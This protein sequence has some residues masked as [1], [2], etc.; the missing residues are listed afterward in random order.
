MSDELFADFPPEPPPALRA[1]HCDAPLA[2]RLRPETFEDFLGQEDLLGPG[3][4]LRS[5]IE[6]GTIPSIIFWGPPGCGKTTL[7]LLIAKTLHADVALLSAVTSQLRE[8]RQVLEQARR[9]RQQARRTLLFV[10]EIHR[11][12]KAQQDAFLPAVESGIITLI[13]ATTENPSFSVIAPL[14]SRCRVFTLKRL[15]ESHLLAL[16]GRALGDPARGL[17]GAQVRVGEDTL[18]S[19]IALSDGDARKALSLLE[20]GVDAARAQEA[21]ELTG[22]TLQA[23][24][25]RHLIYDRSGEEHF[26]LISAFHKSLRSSDPQ[27][28][29]YWLARMLASG[30]DPLYVARRMV[31]FATEDIGLADPQALP[32]ALA[33]HQTYHMLGSP[34]GELALVQATVYL[35]TAPKSN[36]LYVAEKRLKTEIERSGS[37]PVPLA[38]R[39]APTALM[40]EWGYGAQYTYDH[41]APDHF[42]PKQCLP[43]DIQAREFYTPGG[44][45]FEREIQKRLA[46]WD[47]KRHEAQRQADEKGQ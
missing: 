37:L 18:R 40:K 4:P 45:G 12:N 20:M 43:D 8:V 39:N 9:N 7:A 5:L 17:A 38:L 33:A 11:F 29:L 27:A 24:A 1:R 14:L 16:L 31:R 26:N 44:F 47:K 36:S 6:R 10:D 34:E 2:D 23:L 15:G 25:Q 41:D 21:A 13:G 35:A 32:Q 46:W 3:R 28:A 42:V 30:E 22:E 19:I